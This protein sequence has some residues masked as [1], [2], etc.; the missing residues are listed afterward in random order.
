[1]PPRSI[2]SSAVRSM[3]ANFIHMDAVL[4]ASPTRCSQFPHSPCCNRVL[5][6]GEQGPSL[7]RGANGVP[8]ANAEAGDGVE[9]RK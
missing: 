9:G 5:G 2:T 7:Q 8:L 4:G 3:P 1:M 6:F